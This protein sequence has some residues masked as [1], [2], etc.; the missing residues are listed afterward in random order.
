VAAV[1]RRAGAV[2]PTAAVWAAAVAAAAAGGV[3]LAWFM[4]HRPY[5]TWAAGP[6]LA[7]L[8]ILN[9]PLLRR[10]ARAE[11][12]PRIA[13]LLWWAFGLKMLASVP[14]YIIAF[15]L[16][17]G[18]ADANSYS[19]IGAVL[20]RQFRDGQLTVDLGKPVQGTGFIE[21]LT[22]VVYSITGATTVGGFFVFSAFGFWG[23]YLFHRAFVRSFPDGDHWRYARLV[24]LLPSLLFWPSSIGKE[25]WMCL[26]LGVV[27][28]AA[29]RMLTGARGGVWMLAV[30]ALMLNT[31]R[32]HVAA[33]AVFS[34]F[35]AYLVRRPP[36]R[37]FGPAP[38]GK[39]VVVF[40]LGLSMVYA[41]GQLEQ[42]FGVDEFNQDA[43]QTTLNEVQRQTGQGGSQFVEDS[44]TNLSP[45]RFPLA[46]VNVMFRPFPWQATNPQALVSAVE[47][48][49]LF[50][51]VLSSWR[52][53][54]TAAS[55]LV[56]RPY[57][58]LCGVY[59]VL[60]VYGFSS[61]SNAGILVRQRVQVLPFVLVLVCLPVLARR[62]SSSS[63]TDGHRHRSS[64]GASS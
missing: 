59:T 57:L 9:V 12:D 62:G 28:Y 3:A 43:V 45:S 29:S 35:V 30:G 18:T 25:A 50:V 33:I 40:L 51:L 64:N 47:A 22:G 2:Q 53:L 61:F 15:D 8:V 48:S 55:S 11:V 44:G 24:F 14:R 6:V 36:K 21:I 63:D 5:D 56:Q 1:L 38:T 49:F 32:P 60:F 20:A 16:Y 54:L 58:V 39:L 4:E 7:A 27:T 31:V 37:A 42:F 46:F 34:I 17:D 19:R 52:S 41:V 10:A 13:N 23:L 26:G